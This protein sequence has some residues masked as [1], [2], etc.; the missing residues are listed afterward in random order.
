MRVIGL[1]VIGVICSCSSD[2]V[3]D[4]GDNFKKFVKPCFDGE[5][6]ENTCSE[7]S[8]SCHEKLGNEFKLVR[9]DGVKTGH[10]QWLEVGPGKTVKLITR[11]MRPLIFEIPEFL[12]DEEC[13]RIMSLAKDSGLQTSTSGF[14][15]YDGDLDEDLAKAGEKESKFRIDMQLAAPFHVFNSMYP[16]EPFCQPVS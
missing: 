9:L 11:A 13:N 12:S 16:H 6:I 14:F 15:N 1:L 10:V 2:T 4:R 7:P 3:V 8:D 5:E